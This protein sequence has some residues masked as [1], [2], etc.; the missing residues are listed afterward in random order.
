MTSA[1][2]V[3]VAEVVGQEHELRETA[4]APVPPSRAKTLL[5]GIP[6][7]EGDSV[8]TRAVR[9]GRR[10]TAE[11]C[12]VWRVHGRARLDRASF[13][14]EGPHDWWAGIVNAR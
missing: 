7:A 12:D 13:R 1:P 10:R 2:S 11:G 4:G 8:G 6:M 9:D 14:S 3:F 5:N